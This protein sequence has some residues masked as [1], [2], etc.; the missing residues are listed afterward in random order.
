MGEKGG[1]RKASNI[2]TMKLSI[3]KMSAMLGG[4]GGAVSKK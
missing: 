4:G 2:F 1:G 3:L